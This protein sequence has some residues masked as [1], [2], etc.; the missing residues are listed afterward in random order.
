MSERERERV[1]ECVSEYCT[2]AS[3]SESVPT[4]LTL[5]P[6]YKPVITEPKFQVPRD[7]YFFPAFFSH[8]PQVHVRYASIRRR[9]YL[10]RFFLLA[11]LQY[12]AL[13]TCSLHTSLCTLPSHHLGKV[14][15]G[16]C[17]DFGGFFLLAR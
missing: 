10:S 7:S 14:W 1:C 11:Y 5:P 13:Y 16:R 6:R 4:Y 2:Y 9:V 15:Y 17:I 8:L 12:L 3:N